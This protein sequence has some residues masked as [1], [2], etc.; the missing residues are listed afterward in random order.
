MKHNVPIKIMG[1]DAIPSFEFLKNHLQNKTFLTKKMLKNNILATNMVY[2]NIFHNKN[3]L[4]KYEK[5]LDK[6]FF[7]ISNQNI[8]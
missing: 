1:T 8:R 5:V 2:I 4:V 7:D 6:I 3:N